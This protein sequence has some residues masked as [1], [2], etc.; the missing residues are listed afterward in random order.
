MF[1]SVKPSIDGFPAMVHCFREPA[2]PNVPASQWI[3]RYVGTNVGTNVG[4]NGRFLHEWWHEWHEC[5]LG[6]L[7]QGD[8]LVGTVTATLGC[9]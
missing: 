6:V 5:I 1:T 3:G 9:L 4:K 7:F 2:P 8:V